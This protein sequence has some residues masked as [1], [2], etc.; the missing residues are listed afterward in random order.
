MTDRLTDAR[1]LVSVVTVCFDAERHLAEAMESVLGQTYPDIEYL[2]VDGGSTDGTLDVICSFESRFGGRLRWISEPDEG[3]YD[4]MNRGIDMAEGELVGLLNADDAYLPDAI[5]SV[6]AAYAESPDAGAVYGDVHVVDDAGALVRTESAREPAQMP[7]RPEQMPFCH[8][9]LF[10][11]RWAYEQLGGYD[12]RFHVLA[13]Y[14]W[15]LS[16]RAADLPMVHVAVPLVRF[17]LG[18]AC[19][20][21]M[22]RSNAERERIRVRYGANPLIERAKRVRHSVSR[23]V[24]AALRGGRA[25]SPA[26]P[27]GERCEQ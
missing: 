23:M 26:A 25:V 2:V 16:A 6:V 15:V 9:S 4:A 27:D 17:R 21:D 18:G 10:V 14:E 7:L 11:A 8:Q 20:A 3:I 24:Y 13:D 22:A 19:S 1:P 5:E 12:T